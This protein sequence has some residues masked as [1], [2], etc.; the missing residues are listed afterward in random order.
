MSVFRERLFAGKTAFLTGGTSGIGLGIAE[1]F[2]RLGAHVVLAGRNEEKMARAVAGIVAK[3][4]SATGCACDVRDYAAIESVLKTAYEERGPLD[5]VFAAAA[6]NFSAPVAGMSSNGF[7]AVMDID[8][9]GTFNTYRAA[10]A[11]LRKPGSVLVSISAN[12]AHQAIAMQA[13]V[14][15]AKAAVELL[16]K[17]LALEWAKDGVRA[18]CI[19]PG[20]IDETEGMRRL[21]PT[22]EARA[23]VCAAVPLGRMGTKEEVADLAVFLCSDAAAYVTGAVFACDGGSGLVGTRLVEMSS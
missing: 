5:F 7:K 6:G 9:L 13:H 21:A 19:T 16:T 3:G 15:A 18:V 22:E 23:E 2:A 8:A 12:H 11:F 20:P 10:Y 17:T 1:R 4:G 14:C